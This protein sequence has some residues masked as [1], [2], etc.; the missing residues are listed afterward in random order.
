MFRTLLTCPNCQRKVSLEEA[1]CVI[2]TIPLPERSTT[3]KKA[4]L[5]YTV[6]PECRRDIRVTGE[7]T[8]A[9]AVLA[10][11]FALLAAS[12][13]MGDSW[14]PLALVAATLIGQKKIAQ[15]FIRT[16]RA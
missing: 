10:S 13:A 9:I 16:H 7:R 15:L 2:P 5:V 3:F 12:L 11:V 6:C 4:A 1:R 8:A 14:V